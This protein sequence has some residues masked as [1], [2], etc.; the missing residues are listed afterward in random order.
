MDLRGAVECEELGSESRA[1]FDRRIHSR[2]VCVRV[3]Q[4]VMDFLQY[5]A[6]LFTPYP[7]LSTVIA[8]SKVDNS[9]LPMAHFLSTF[10]KTNP[11]GLDPSFSPWYTSV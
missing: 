8:L 4:T 7:V 11:F 6:T 1:D 3:C 5:L 2:S 9:P 10:F